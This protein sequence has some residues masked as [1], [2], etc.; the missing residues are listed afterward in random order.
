MTKFHQKVKT[1]FLVRDFATRVWL[2]LFIELTFDQITELKIECNPFAKGFREC[3]LLPLGTN[4][5]TPLGATLI[6]N[7]QISGSPETISALQ[8]WIAAIVQAKF[9]D[10]SGRA[11]W[12]GGPFRAPHYP[13]I[14]FRILSKKLKMLR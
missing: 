8:Q 7:P 13:K 14:S 11:S 1:A 4:G 2:Y 6:G 3:D 12:I 5:T 10:K 9:G